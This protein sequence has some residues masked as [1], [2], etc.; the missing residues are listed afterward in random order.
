MTAEKK[1]KTIE[2]KHNKNS[3]TRTLFI[4]CCVT[5]PIIQFLVFYVY[6]NAS[7]IVLAFTNVSGEFT[8]DNF[9]R[10]FKEFSLETSSIR[11]AF[12]NTLLTFGILFITFPFK[13]LVSYF[14]Y[15]KIPG[16]K[17][18]RILFF[19]PMV[20]FSICTTL[21]FTRIVGAT[22]FVAKAVGE[23]L[24]LGYTPD[25]LGDS[26]FANTVV[27]VHLLWLGFPGDLII[28]G[29]TFARIPGDMF[30]A[31]RVDGTNWWSEFT[32]IV[33][34]LIWPTLALKMVLLFCTIF[35]ATG[36][37]FLLTRGAY[38]TMTLQAWQYIQLVDNTST[39][40]YNYLS[41]V[42]LLLSIVAIAISLTVRK[43]TDK[44]F[45]DVEY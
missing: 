18:Y 40:A 20:I 3:K 6:T 5:L 34:P 8:L 35:S 36:A 2:V 28:W 16:H 25:L 43:I 9:K 4:L 38:G 17:V 1:T 37:V 13:T 10:F 27:I 30:E 24:H 12:R 32:R 44:Y 33:V 7:S 15:K 11:I 29:G 21:M 19:L 31:G 41:A 22:S 14:L 26:R 39:A 42:G 45:S 23:W